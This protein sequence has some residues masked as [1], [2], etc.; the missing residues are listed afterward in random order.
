ME[1]ISTCWHCL[2]EC[3]HLCVIVP[4]SVCVSSVFCS[5]SVRFVVFESSGQRQVQN[6]IDADWNPKIQKMNKIH[7]ETVRKYKSTANTRDENREHRNSNVGKTGSH[8]GNTGSRQG[9]Q[10]IWPWTKKLNWYTVYRLTRKQ[11]C[12]QLPEPCGRSSTRRTQ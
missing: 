7:R 8:T 3:N 9:T 10:T 12:N 11:W 1:N 5:W 4:S 6:N 2:C